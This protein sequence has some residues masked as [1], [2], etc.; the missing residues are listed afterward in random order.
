[1]EETCFPFKP[2]WLLKGLGVGLGE[3]P[4]PL[5]HLLDVLPPPLLCQVFWFRSAQEIVSWERREGDGDLDSCFICSID[6]HRIFG[7][8]F[9]MVAFK[10]P[11]DPVQFNAYYV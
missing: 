5:Q 6:V 4:L 1:M 3:M 8:W 11:L 2:F 10:F 9:D 7:I